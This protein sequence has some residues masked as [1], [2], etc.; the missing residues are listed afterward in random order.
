MDR[1]NGQTPADAV[2]PAPPTTDPGRECDFCGS[3]P[4]THW[5]TFTPAAPDSGWTLPDRLGACAA[6]AHG[7]DFSDADQLARVGNQPTDL[8]GVLA[9]HFLSIKG[10]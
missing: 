4:T 9:E 5:L 6:C 2:P 10:P 1:M 7:I 8:A 3:T